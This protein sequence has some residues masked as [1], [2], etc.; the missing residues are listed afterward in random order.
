MTKG[1]CPGVLFHLSNAP[2]QNNNFVDSM[3]AAED[4]GSEMIY[5]PLY[6]PDL[7]P[8]HYFLFPNIT[9]HLA[10]QQYW[11]DDDVISADEDFSAEEHQARNV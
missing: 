10:E 9:Y 3:A 6:Y 4:C 7:A 8:T 5:Y 2:V 1:P 11:S